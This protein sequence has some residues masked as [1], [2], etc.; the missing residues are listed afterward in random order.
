MDTVALFNNMIQPPPPGIAMKLPHAERMRLDRTPYELQRTLAKE[1]QTQSNRAMREGMSQ[2][3]DMMK[4]NAAS[5]GVT[6]EQLRQ[7]GGQEAQAFQTI[8]QM[9]QQISTQENA[10][11]TDVLNKEAITN[12]EI[13]A[14]AKEA[15][16]A[17]INKQLEQVG[18][19]MGAYAHY[20]HSKDMS[21]K[22]TKNMKQQADASN[23][24]QLAMLE[25]EMMQK[26]IESEPYK[27]AERKVINDYMIQ[28]RVALLDDPRYK[29]LKEK[30]GENY[31]PLMQS[32]LNEE[33][34]TNLKSGMERVK[35]E[36]KNFETT[37]VKPTVKDLEPK[38]S[39]ETDDDFNKR[40]KQ[41]DDA[42]AQIDKDYQDEL[43]D[44]NNNKKQYDEAQKVLDDL[45]STLKIE[46]QF[47]QDLR[48]SYQTGEEKRK[49][50]SEW[51]KNKGLPES[52]DILQTVKDVLQSYRQV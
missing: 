14:R 26:E 13:Q 39:T 42:V 47:Q 48:G 3:S 20:L 18:N 33:R 27:E 34:A 24:I 46:K 11:Q 35:Q 45:E 15:K 21:E 38:K 2:A 37:P 51:L 44:F 17:N 4:A 1:T 25:H 49:F 12:Y 36:Y 16:D 30:Y 8:D 29:T 10:V 6:Q 9:N 19:T 41:Y 23:R 28:N 32:S 22:M 52:M 31:D 43:E 5:Q 7:V 50:Q 40:K